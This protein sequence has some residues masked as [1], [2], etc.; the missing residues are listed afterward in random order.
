MRT[1]KRLKGCL[2][3]LGDLM[4]LMVFLLK[5]QRIKGM[6]IIVKGLYP[7]A[8]CMH[9]KEHFFHALTTHPMT[10]EDLDDVIKAFCKG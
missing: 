5:G 2:E 1:G 7:I 6:W 9:E 4:P 8:E 10:K 3:H